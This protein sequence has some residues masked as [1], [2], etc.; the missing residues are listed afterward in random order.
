MALSKGTQW[1]S[2]SEFFKICPFLFSFL[3]F[4]PV[5]YLFGGNPLPDLR[6][7]PV[8]QG[9]EW[10]K[11]NV[12]FSPCTAI[13]STEF[14]LKPRCIP[15]S[16]ALGNLILFFAYMQAESLA[17]DYF[18]FSHRIGQHKLLTVCWEPAGDGERKEKPRWTHT[19]PLGVNVSTLLHLTLISMM[20]LILF[21]CSV[22]I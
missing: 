4:P 14:M 1:R 8:N 17:G 10:K 11:T 2:L 22:K 15:D 9:R 3:S 18:A 19:K 16:S 21:D 7:P 12:V 13:G 20:R 6:P 5:C